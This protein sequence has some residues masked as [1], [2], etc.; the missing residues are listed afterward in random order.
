MI[1]RPIYEYEELLGSYG[2]I[3]CHQSHLVNKKSVKSW[4]REDGSYLLLED[5]VQVPVSRQKKDA[6]KQSLENVK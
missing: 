2:F 6:V 5:G 3:R 4:I 1:A